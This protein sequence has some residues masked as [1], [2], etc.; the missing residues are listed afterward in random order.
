MLV[1]GADSP[2]A[3]RFLIALWWAVL[4]LP[5][6]AWRQE[7]NPPSRDVLTLEQAVALAVQHNRLVQNAQLEVEKFDDKLAAARTRR[8]PSFNFYTLGSQQLS[9]INFN[10][11]R[12]IFGTFP[13]IGPIP[14]EDTA[15]STPLRPTAVII[16]QVS[17]PL[18]Q[19]YRISLSLEQL[20]IGQQ[21]AQEQA[22]AQ[23]Q[24]IVNQVKQTYYGILQT[25]SGL[26]AVE[27]GIKLYREL[28]RLTSEYVAQQ[29]ALKSDNLE[30]KTRLARAEYDALTL[31]D[32]LATQKEAL[33]N[34]LGRDVRTEFTVSPVPEATRWETDPAAAQVRALEQRPEVKEAR[35]K[36]KAADFDRRVKKSEF[37]PD[38]SLS[39]N[40]LSPRNF[41]QF[42]PKNIANVGVVLSWEVFDWGRKRRELAEKSRTLQQA[43]NGWQ[44]AENLVLIDVN[45]KFRKLQQT[46]QLLRVAQLTQE[47]ARENLRVTTNRYHQQTTLLKNV[48]QAQTTLAEANYQYQQ[49]LLAFWTAKADFEKALGE[50]Q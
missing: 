35:L 30:V 36:V 19:Q 8:L 13:G 1:A 4:A 6:A 22:R 32:A 14:G 15:I 34:L 9:E 31:S 3:R 25:Q 7:V 40:Y 27:E 17:Q 38:V 5:A 2:R 20:K 11:Q 41:D 33:N 47:T 23:Q 43:H 48:L 39:F 18:S 50:D 26:Q 21:I 49:A 12:G 24:S 28:D 45:S 46:R 37:I 10:F 16:G 29:V 44:V 42:I